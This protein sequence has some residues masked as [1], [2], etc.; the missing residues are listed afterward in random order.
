M[1]DAAADFSQLR[2]GLVASAKAAG[3]ELCIAGGASRPWASSLFVG[4]RHKAV[5]GA[6]SSP[7]FDAWLAAL[8]E[9]DPP[10]SGQFLASA[11]V[12]EHASD[13]RGREI[14]TIDFL[15]VAE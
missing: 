3:F 13:Q 5:I 4:S 10:M 7:A 2:R 8:C 15:T 14:V 9:F 1:T 11:D 6:D 12:V